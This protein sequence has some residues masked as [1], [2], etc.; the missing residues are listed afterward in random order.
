M[1]QFTDIVKESTYVNLVVINEEYCV[2][3]EECHD[4]AKWFKDDYFNKTE[5]E[6]FFNYPLDLSSDRRGTAGPNPNEFRILS[7]SGDTILHAFCVANCPC[8]TKETYV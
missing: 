5:V 6:S 7:Q 3:L 1:F 8:G 4:K 2:G